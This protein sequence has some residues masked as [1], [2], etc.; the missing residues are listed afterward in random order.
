MALS[1]LS[2]PPEESSPLLSLLPHELVEYILRVGVEEGPTLEAKDV[3]SFALS[4]RTCLRYA[5]SAAA[6]LC[7]SY[8]SSLSPLACVRLREVREKDWPQR[9]RAVLEGMNTAA[10]FRAYH[11]VRAI[12]AALF[13]AEGEWA[14]VWLLRDA[15]EEALNWKGWN[16]R[17]G[18]MRAAAGGDE[19]LLRLLLRAGAR[20]NEWDNNGWTPL[21]AASLNGHTDVVKVLASL[22]GIDINK[23]S[24]DWVTPLGAASKE[25][26]KAILRAK[27]AK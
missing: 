27:G 7:P 5:S 23:A 9:T 10:W 17:T 6:M 12:V 3:L 14:T 20:V 22:P 18:L 16:G 8:P 21:R 2:P 4:S 1:P 15:G 26:I 24:N 13:V 11:A 19:R 25:E